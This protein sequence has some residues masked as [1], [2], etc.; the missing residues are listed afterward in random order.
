MKQIDLLKNLIRET[1]DEMAVDEMARI[2]TGYKLT[3]DY[4]TK[5]KALPANVQASTRT[6][7]VVNF[8]KDNPG[9]PKTE[10][11]S[12]GGFGG[13]QQAVNQIVNGLEMAGVVEKTGYTKEKAEKAP[14][15]SGER[16]RPKVYDDE[17]RAK[18]A[19]GATL[20]KKF[21]KGDTD[22]TSEE[23]AYITD[24]YNSLNK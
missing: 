9:A 14:V 8:L 11:S 10:I 4:E 13:D 17:M 6:T 12:G 5:L 21:V 7:R 18:M 20:A 3:D 16:G 15:G 23:A 2:S 1:I 24:L 22:Y 19:M